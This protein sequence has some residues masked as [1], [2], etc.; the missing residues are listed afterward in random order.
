MKKNVVY[1]D[2]PK[3]KVNIL[4][5]FFLKRGFDLY[6]G[7]LS[8][9]GKNLYLAP[10]QIPTEIIVALIGA[11]GVVVAELIKVIKQREEGK[12][13]Q[14]TKEN[15]KKSD[16]ERKNGIA[17]EIE[18]SNVYKISINSNVP[19]EEIEITVKTVSEK[20]SDIR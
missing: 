2:G 17:V 3:D 13:Q 16:D 7:T 14:S 20:L 18:G 15:A 1:I 8:N 11:A 10:P 9:E 19:I 6:D 5:D 12:K 4:L